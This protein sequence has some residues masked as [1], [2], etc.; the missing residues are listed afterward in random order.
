MPFTMN[1]TEDK[2]IYPRRENYLV[3]VVI[4]GELDSDTRTNL[5]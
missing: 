3:R 4:V 5:G 2:E 1:M